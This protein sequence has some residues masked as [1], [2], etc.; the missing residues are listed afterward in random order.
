MTCCSISIWRSSIR[1]RGTALANTLQRRH[2]AALID[3]FQDTDPVQYAIFQRI[4]A[5]TAQPLFLVGDPK[6]AIYKAFAAPTSL[7]IWRRGALLGSA[8]RWMSTG[9][10][11]HACS[12]P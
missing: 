11:I 9:V 6:Q 1:K 3:E 2:A 12:P 8:T 10:P 7:R 5:G 4:Y